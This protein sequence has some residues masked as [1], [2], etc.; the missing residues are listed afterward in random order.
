MPSSIQSVLLAVLVAGSF[1]LPALAQTDRASVAGVIT[2]KKAIAESG[3]SHKASKLVVADTRVGSQAVTSSKS[4]VFIKGGRFLMGTSDQSA[5]PA[6]TPVHEVEVHSF[7]LD[8]Y[9]VTVGQFAGFVKATGYKTESERFGWSGVFDVRQHDWT[10]VD[11]AYWHHP[12]GTSSKSARP[13][14][15]VTQVSWDDAVAY[16]GWTNKRLP[17]EAEFEYAARGGLAGK[18][19]SWG[20][21]LRPQGKYRAN[22]WQGTFPAKDQGEDGYAGR[23]PVG[24][25]PPNGYGLY[26]IAGNVWEWCSDWFD[27]KYY[28]KS[29]RDD[30]HGPSTGTDRVTRGGSWLC[31][32]N[33]CTGYRVASRNHATPDSALNNLGFRCVTDK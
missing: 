24:S 15:P 25:F 13:N 2:D 7:W 9:P 31:S 21:E 23:S 26:D 5:W 8:V 1:V 10:R 33:Y 20:N 3:R 27:D 4:M 30:P 28:E 14:E 6:E 32:A 16:C 17:T 11:G 29:P 19:Y 18:K 22:Y 12:E